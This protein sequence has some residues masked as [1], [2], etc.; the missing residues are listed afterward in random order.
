MNSV[1]MSVESDPTYRQV[2]EAS[3]PATR[4][5]VADGIVAAAREIAE[6][7]EIAAICC[8]TQ[9][10]KTASLVARER[11]RVPIIALS[12]VVGTLRKLCL[13]WGAHNVHCEEVERFKA[14]VVNAAR[15]AR[16]YGFGDETDQIVVTAGVPFNVQGTT[17]IL[18]VAPCD[19]RLIFSADPE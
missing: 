16:A 11:P 14:A 8:Y 10:G 13:T 6:T 2:I 7:T 4:K 17:N 9:S 18:R 12:P 5:T 3:R 19:E 15:A 1:A